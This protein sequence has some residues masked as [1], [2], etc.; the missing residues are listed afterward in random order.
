[1]TELQLFWTFFRVSLVAFGGVFGAL[2]ELQRGIVERGWMTSEQF[3]QSYAVGQFVPGPN[4]AMCALIGYQVDGIPGA[5]AGFLGIYATPLMF[6][7][8]AALVFARYGQVA[9]VRR[10][11]LAVRPI[12]FG[13]IASSALGLMWQQGRENLP[14]ALLLGGAGIA[15]YLTGKL[16]ALRTIFLVGLAWWLGTRGIADGV[17]WV[18]EGFGI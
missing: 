8:I 12:V 4:M 17:G 16:G 15:L 14:L 10:V 1:M 9:W 3:V 6:M 13:L 2:P 18:R 7:G 5:I 11:E